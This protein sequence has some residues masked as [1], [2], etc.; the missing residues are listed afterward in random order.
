[1]AKEKRF[2]NGSKIR[3]NGCTHGSVSEIIKDVVA[4]SNKLGS[5]ICN[6]VETVAVRATCGATTKADAVETTSKRRPVVRIMVNGG[7]GGDVRL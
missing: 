1:M 5:I 4:W 2:K 3:D 6:G 7:H